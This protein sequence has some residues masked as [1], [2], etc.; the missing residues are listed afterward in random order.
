VFFGVFSLFSGSF[1]FDQPDE[2]LIFSLSIGSR[3]I[4]NIS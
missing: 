2:P 3:V 1:A 4:N